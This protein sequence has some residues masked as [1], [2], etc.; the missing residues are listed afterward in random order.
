MTKAFAFDHLVLAVSDI[1]VSLTWYQHH[2]GLEGVR[3]DEWRRQE[4]PFPS[5]R[6]SVDTLIDLIP[7]RDGHGGHLNHICFAVTPEDLAEVRANAE[8]VIEE[9]G[10][11]FGA[12]GVAQSVYVRDPD[13]LLVEIRAYPA[14]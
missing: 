11:R 4:V 10:F 9:E 3:V 7:G 12:R 1:E 2:L 13:G 5:L 14:A 6:V 8:L